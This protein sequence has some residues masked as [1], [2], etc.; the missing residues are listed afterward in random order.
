MTTK[1]RIAFVH[2]GPSLSLSLSLTVTLLLVPRPPSFTKSF[3]SCRSICCVIRH[4]KTSEI[5]TFLLLYTFLSCNT[6]QKHVW[7]HFFASFTCRSRRRC[8]AKKISVFFVFVVLICFRRPQSSALP[9]LF[10][11]PHTHSSSSFSLSLALSSLLSLTH[12]ESKCRWIKKNV[13]YGVSF[14]ASFRSQHLHWQVIYN[15]NSA[16]AHHSLSLPLL[17]PIK[18]LAFLPHPASFEPNQWPC[19]NTKKD[20]KNRQKT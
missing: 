9:V 8:T 15:W 10:S 11:R 12:H 14:Y 5:R 17:I 1:H 13:S 18:R 4:N 3:S 7:F 6:A 16:L 19:K 20:L 2:L